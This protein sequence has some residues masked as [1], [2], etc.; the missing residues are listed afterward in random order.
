MRKMLVHELSRS[1]TTSTRMAQSRYTTLIWPHSRYDICSLIIIIIIMAGMAV[2]SSTKIFLLQCQQKQIVKTYSYNNNK[3]TFLITRFTMSTEIHC[4]NYNSYNN[5]KTTFSY[6]VC[7]Q[8]K[9]SCMFS[10]IGLI[11]N[12][13]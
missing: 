5:D 2:F 7:R 10:M 8:V 6:L 1:C 9:P 13:L 12:L 11:L 3:A 4:Q